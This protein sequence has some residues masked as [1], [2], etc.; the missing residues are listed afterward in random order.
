MPDLEALKLK[1]TSDS[2][3]A[4]NGI[5][6]LS[7]ALTELKASSKGSTSSLGT[8]SKRLSELSSAM[9]GVSSGNAIKLKNL[10]EAL[11]ALSSVGKINITATTV[12]NL[13]GLAEA[14]KAFDGASTTKFAEQMRETA[15]GLE[16]ISRASTVSVKSV[17]Q[18][19]G[20]T[21][22]A[23]Q[24]M[25]SMNPAASVA[26]HALG[27][28]RSGVSKT[29]LTLGGFEMIT[30]RVVGVFQRGF[31]NVSSYVENMNLFNVAMA[32]G[33]V[34]A[35][36][37][38]DKVQAA[39]G[40]DAGEWA[41]NQGVFQ[42]LITGFGVTSD[43]ADRM[44]RN[45]T[46]LGYDLSSFYNL[47]V[48]D[49]QQKIQSGISGELEP[50]R[51][52]GFDLSQ[53]RLQQIAYNNGIT[54]SINTMNQA[55]KSQLRYIAIMTQVTHAQGDMARTIYQPANAMR[56]LKQQVSLLSR[57][58]GAMLL[59]AM[60]R[61]LPVA[62]SVMQGL[63]KVFNAIAKLFGYTPPK[64]DI[65]NYSNAATA[66]GDA[67]AAT[68]D[69]G[70]NAKKTGKSV[71][72]LTKTLKKY[73]KQLLG[74][75]K[76]NNL[77]TTTKTKTP[78]TGK[79]GGGS[80]KGAGGVGAGQFDIDIPEYDFLQGLTDAFGRKHPKIKAFFDWLAKNIK[81]VGQVITSV[82][83]GAVIAKIVSKFFHLFTGRKLG[84]KK[85]FGIFL[86]AAGAIEAL[87][88]Q[89][90]IFKQ[91]LTTGNLVKL[92]GSLAAAVTGLFMAF[93]TKGGGIGLIVSG[94]L[95]FFNGVLDA[96]KNGFNKKNLVAIGGGLTAVAAGLF[97][98]K[99][100]KAGLA[101]LAIGAAIVAAL[102]IFKHRKEIA[103]FFKKLWAGIKEKAAEIWPKAKK[104]GIEVLKG[105]LYYYTHPF[106][107][108]KKATKLLFKGV[109]KAVKKIFGIH[110]P[111]KEMKPL[112]KQILQ[113]IVSGMTDGVTKI[114]TGAADTIKEAVKDA[115]S[116]VIDIK[117]MIMGGAKDIALSLTAK[118]DTGKAAFDEF[119]NAVGG[120][121]TKGLNAAWET[122]KDLATSFNA[123][124]SEKAS[125][126]L[127]TSKG[128]WATKV[129]KAFN[130]IKTTQVYKN[131][132]A[133][134][135]AWAAKAVN[136]FNALKNT[137]IYKYLGATKKNWKE[138]AVSAFNG[139]KNKTA[140]VTLAINNLLTK[141]YNKV[142]SA[143]Q[144]AR[145]KWP[146]VRAVLPDI[147]PMASGGFPAQGQL[148]VAREAGPEMVG[149]MGGRT[150]VANNDQI[151]AGIAAG[152][153]SA[154]ASQNAL[155]RQII[156]AIGAEGESRVVLQINETQLGEVSIKAIN[157]VQRM[158]G[159]TL[160][161]V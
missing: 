67:A 79:T 29:V 96:Y 99:S 30:R 93:G 154:N 111:S 133:Q 121:V 70:K 49:A 4:A 81:D 50:L 117:D 151:V 38:A 90:D 136:A 25:R 61:I 32:E 78:K 142:A 101:G 145:K 91:G 31:Q 62:I 88:T 123:I 43:Y 58:F 95:L 161:N 148:F 138:K 152:V 105:F 28:L 122:G 114:F 5:R 13:T 54:Q 10:A 12:K 47:S 9:N 115:L 59:P 104:I 1:I 71:K 97:V 39:L 98:L 36:E 52:L 40:I 35:G 113:G 66:A 100:A 149:T 150:A 15:S 11:K 56:V 128:S 72:G 17:N 144:S 147:H 139:L 75:D 82:L 73:T 160:L 106:A 34:K 7:S 8:V 44:S 140:T 23:A 45:L 109:V 65:K 26:T 76:I 126:T 127:N 102:L 118:W 83:G 143:I 18:L 153:A 107:F 37:Y 131:L 141:G 132:G 158:Q 156:N 134:K 64:L 146:A 85:T 21:K 135:K 112:G 33:A 55:Q 119:K 22:Y 89:M 6:Q 69:I 155:L 157:K 130:A 24:N 14:V 19:A 42:S 84:L 3:Q 57:A 124:K 2:Q 92:L 74:F 48:S 125:K 110:S 53:A 86:F 103:K 60:E 108:L 51:R 87:R 94:V 68:G 80:G 16:A 41:R 120:S 159:R 46:Q 20:K 27:I 129:V 77:T 63:V 116:G 137:Q